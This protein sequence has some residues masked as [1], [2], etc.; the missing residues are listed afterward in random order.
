ME[1]EPTAQCHCVFVG[2]MRQSYNHWTIETKYHTNQVASDHPLATW[3]HARC[4][5][6]HACHVCEARTREL[7]PTTPMLSG[8]AGEGGTFLS[9]T[10]EAA[11]RQR[12]GWRRALASRRRGQGSG[13]MCTAATAHSGAALGRTFD[14][15]TLV[16]GPSSKI[17]VCHGM[18]HEQGYNSLLEVRLLLM[19]RPS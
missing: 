5:V 13:H 1:R 15:I 8:A 11:S 3:R 18:R 14:V 4:V 9:D 6:M 10:Q 12:R 16:N 2:G 17:Q 19:C 7:M